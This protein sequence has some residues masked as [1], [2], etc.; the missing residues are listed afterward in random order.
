VLRMT[1]DHDFGWA[2]LGGFARELGRG[3]KKQP[4]AGVFLFLFI[5]YFPFLLLIFSFI[6]L[7]II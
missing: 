1:S 7:F 2:E 5:F 6:I 3:Q 4:S